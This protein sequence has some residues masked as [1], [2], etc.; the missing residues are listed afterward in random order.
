M[1]GQSSQRHS[2]EKTLKPF[3]GL[4]A[5]APPAHSKLACPPG[6]GF[7]DPA[8][9]VFCGPPARE[10]W[11]SATQSEGANSRA[12][13]RY[14]PRLRTDPSP[15][16]P[17]STTKPPTPPC[18]FPCCPPRTNPDARLEVSPTSRLLPPGSDPLLSPPPPSRSLPGWSQE[19]GGAFGEGNLNKRRVLRFY[20]HRGGASGA[21]RPEHPVGWEPWTSSSLRETLGAGSFRT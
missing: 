16:R 20:L 4:E 13:G 7:R 10:P 15:T 11:C 2:T 8:P 3:P 21:G 1:A 9:P 5:A 14:A 19:W 18:N 12:W 6:P 17:R